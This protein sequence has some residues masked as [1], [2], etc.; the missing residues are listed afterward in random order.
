MEKNKNLE[1]SNF[2]LGQLFGS[3]ESANNSQDEDLISVIRFDKTG[4]YLALGD[5]AGR[6][7]IF[8]N[9]PNST[10]NYEYFAEVTTCSI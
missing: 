4:N 9:Q 10:M 1:V 3:K 5:H 6:V 2:K 7:I 8:H